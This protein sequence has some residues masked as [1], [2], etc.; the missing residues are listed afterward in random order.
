MS[1][2]PPGGLEDRYTVPLEANRRGAHRARPNPLTGTLP[3]VAVAVVVIAVIAGAFVLLGSGLL[4]S[5]STSASS[6]V[7][8]A[9]PRP[10]NLPTGPVGA[11]GP[12]PGANISPTGPSATTQAQSSVK[13]V[14]LNSTNTTGLAKKAAAALQAKGWTVL[15]TG[16]FTGS[17]VTKTTVFYA[18]SAEAATANEVATDLGVGTTNTTKQSSTVATSGITVVLGTDYHP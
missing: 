12:L 10:S 13:L 17:G 6:S 8:G 16:N 1:S 9:L 5:R 14:V 11:T 2:M 18:Q 7:A 15:R 3:V 4:P